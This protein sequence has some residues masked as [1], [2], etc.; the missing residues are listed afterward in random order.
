MCFIL[1]RL[2]SNKKTS[3][4]LEEVRCKS[5]GPGI[6]IPKKEY[7]NMGLIRLSLLFL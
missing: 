7:T 1:I 6:C 2:I 5:V 3:P 4:I